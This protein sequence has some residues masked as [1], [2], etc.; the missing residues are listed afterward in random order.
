M[1]KW[2]SIEDQMP[3]QGKRVMFVCVLDSDTIHEPEIGEWTGE[4]TRGDAIVMDYGE[5]DDWYPCTHWM[6]LPE[7]M[8]L[9]DR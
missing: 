5:E 3:E 2:I 1:S 6:E 7:Y 4:R 8:S 9:V